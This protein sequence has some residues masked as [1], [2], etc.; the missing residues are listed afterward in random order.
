[1]YPCEALPV[2][3]LAP[4]GG[5]LSDGIGRRPPVVV[6]SVLVVAG[7]TALLFG[8]SLFFGLL[9]PIIS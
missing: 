9:G 3:L 2:A 6:G 5:R 4:V 8:I 1:M 7:V